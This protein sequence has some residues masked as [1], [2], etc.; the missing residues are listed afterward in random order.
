MIADSKVW[1]VILFLA[2]GTFAIRFSFLA[3]LGDRELPPL[4]LRLLRYT[5]IAV[6][7]GMVA[8]LVLW[9]DATQGEVDPLRIAAA[10]VAL[11]VGMWRRSFMPAALSGA[12][13][14]YFGLWVL[15][16]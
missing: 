15:T 5:P 8:P 2:I 16:G 11:G 3:L 7:P 14:F 6:L 13:T 9:P 4:V 12:F 1:L 10:L